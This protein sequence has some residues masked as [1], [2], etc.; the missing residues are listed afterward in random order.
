MSTAVLNLNVTA[1]LTTGVKTYI[2]PRISLS[3]TLGQFTVGALLTG[4]TTLTP[5]S[6]TVSIV[7]LMP[8]TAATV[9][10]RQPGSTTGIPLVLS[11]T[12][13]RWFVLPIGTAFVVNAS[14]PISG[15]EVLY[16]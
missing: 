1:E 14:A 10:I 5:P 4:D 11:P 7:V 8:P 9:T 2:P 16:L 3:S 6:G 13:V 12:D 15:I